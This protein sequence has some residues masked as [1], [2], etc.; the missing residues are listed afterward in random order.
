MK[1]LGIMVIVFWIGWFGYRLGKNTA[2]AWYA[3]HPV[4]LIPPAKFV[5]PE[6]VGVKETK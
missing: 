2:D 6:R 3:Q 4:T 5:V 1:T